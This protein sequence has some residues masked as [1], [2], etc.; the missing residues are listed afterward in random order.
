LAQ[1]LSPGQVTAL[2]RNDHALD[3]TRRAVSERGLGNVDF[4]VGDAMELPFE[5]GSFDIVHAHQVLQHVSDPVAV[6]KEMKRVCKP[7]GIVAARDS[8]YG[9]F[10]WV[11]HDPLLDRWMSLYQTANRNAGGEPNAGRHLLAWANEAGFEDV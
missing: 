1:R 9:G 8:D 7:G 6:L 3:L 2:E 4:V 5:G 11:P 10:V